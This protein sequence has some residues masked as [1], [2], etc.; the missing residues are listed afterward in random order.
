MRVIRGRADIL[1]IVPI[2][3]LTTAEEEEPG[4]VSRSRSEVL[5]LLGTSDTII[6]LYS[7]PTPYFWIWVHHSIEEH[8]ETHGGKIS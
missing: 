3:D 2:I 6:T 4:R 8:S 7:H 5:I 1:I